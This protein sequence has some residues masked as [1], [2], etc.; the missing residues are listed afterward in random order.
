MSDTGPGMTH[1]DEPV[2]PTG[3]EDEMTHDDQTETDDDVQPAMTHD[4]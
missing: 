1:D 4:G 2:I 3:G